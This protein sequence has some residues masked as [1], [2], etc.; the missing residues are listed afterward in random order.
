LASDL[1]IDFA[2]QLKVA[3][4][5]GW[6]TEHRFHPTRRWRFDFAWPEKK[7]AVE[8]DGGS[9][10]AGRHSRGGGIHSDCEKQCEAVVLGW[11]VLRCDAEMVRSG[12]ALTY[13]Q[14]VL[15]TSC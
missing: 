9:W 2:W 3:K 7:I 11:R 4:V 14:K 10:I 12:V 6:E 5:T 13:L 15:D 1:E 8:I